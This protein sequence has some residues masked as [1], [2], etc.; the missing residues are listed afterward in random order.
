MFALF[1]KEIRYFF[2][3]AIGFTV[4]GLFI[5]LNGIFLWILKTDYNIFN[6]NSADLL[7]FFR[8][9]SWIF[10]FLVPAL[11]MRSISEEKRSGMLQLLFTKPISIFQIVLGKYLGI[12]F[13]LFV[14]LLPSLLYVYIIWILGNP[15][16]NL[17]IASTV[18]SYIALFLLSATFGAVGLWSSSVSNNQV[19][20]FM[21]AA[22]LCFFFFF[23]LDQ[24]AMLLFPDSVTAFGFQSHFDAISRGV[25]DTRNVFYFLSFIAFFL[26]TTTLSL[27]YYKL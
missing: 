1:N 4:I 10:V 19:I 2:T 22:F 8:L 24:T 18:G 16:G 9:S 14:T 23:G 26:Y 13:L 3:S 27:K 20:S 17:D 25:I 12:L 6:G 11:T 5:V 21:L 7:P 15:V